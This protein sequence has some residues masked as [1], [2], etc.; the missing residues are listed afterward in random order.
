LFFGPE[1][2][3]GRDVRFIE[4][5]FK[6]AGINGEYR[7]DIRKVVWEKYLFVSPLA[8][9]TAYLGKTFGQVMDDAEGRNLLEGLLN[10]VERVGR[11]KGVGLSE[12]IHENSLKKISLFPHDTKSSMQMD[13]EK[14][15]KTELSTFTGYVVKAAEEVGLAVPL[16]KMVFKALSRRLRH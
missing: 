4:P 16:Y 2:S 14:G 12:D 6:Q 11:A 10:E 1:K 7:A 5:V 8:S 9:A 13:F 3:G 15:G